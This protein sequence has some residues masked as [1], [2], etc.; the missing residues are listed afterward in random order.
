M[1]S[2]LNISPSL[3]ALSLPASLPNLPAL[4]P[5]QISCTSILVSLSQHSL[6]QLPPPIPFFLPTL[7]T[8]T[9]LPTPSAPF[10]FLPPHL[11]P[12][13]SPPPSSTVYS[14]KTP[15]L[16]SGWGRGVVSGEGSLAR[17]PTVLCWDHPGPDDHQGASGSQSWQA[18]PRLETC[19]GGVFRTRT[20]ENG[21]ARLLTLPGQPELTCPI[22]AF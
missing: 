7:F 2:S 19:R 15:A 18:R 22:W 16:R 20:W 21:G 13:S 9:S 11:P 10:L 12:A 14:T 1:E 6:S 17:A 5:P 3:C 4:Q 8:A